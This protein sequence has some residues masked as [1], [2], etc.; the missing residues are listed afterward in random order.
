MNYYSIGFYAFAVVCL[1]GATYLK[2]YRL[3]HRRGYRQGHRIGHQQG[4]RAGH[5]TALSQAYRERA[6][7]AFRNG[8]D[9][10]RSEG[11]ES[12]YRQL[13]VGVLGASQGEEEQTNDGLLLEAPAVEPACDGRSEAWFSSL[14]RRL[15]GRRPQAV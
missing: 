4:Q 12:L 1:C 5:K 14:W 7:T 13:L 6:E 2:G 10:G 15:F 3:G 9:W 11:R 8:R